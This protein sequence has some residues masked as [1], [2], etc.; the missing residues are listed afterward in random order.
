MRKPGFYLHILLALTLSGCLLSSANCQDM[1]IRVYTIRDGLPGQYVYG[2]NEDSLGYLWI[3][4]YAGL[5]RFNGTTF[6]NY[7]ISDGLPDSRVGPGLIDSSNRFWITTYR[8]IAEFKG[9]RFISNSPALQGISPYLLFKTNDRRLL[10]MTRNG[11]YEYKKTAWKKGSVYPGYEDHHCRRLIETAEGLYFNYGDLVVLAKKNGE[12]QVIAPAKD[13]GYYY[14]DLLKWGDQ[15]YISTL[16]GIFRIINNQMVRMPGP[17]GQLK[18][19]YSFFIDSKKRFWIAQPRIG[20]QL[21]Q[22]DS[23]EL[24]TVYKGPAAFLPAGIYEDKHGIIWAGSGNGLIRISE[25]GIKD[26]DL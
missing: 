24:K 13:K 8:G 23:S 5:S 12:Y 1:S 18:G 17:L 2:A 20:I 10:A 19:V 14:N 22:N 21:A 11:M 6:T 25:R 9:N 7:G 15:L 26:F 16:D 3:Y 4:T